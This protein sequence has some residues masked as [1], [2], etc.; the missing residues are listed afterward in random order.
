MVDID[1]PTHTQNRGMSH[2]TQEGLQAD[3][4]NN[5]AYP[6][7]IPDYVLH[8]QHIPKHHKPYLI[9][10]VGFTLNNQGQ[11]VKDLTYRG[12][13][14]IQIIECKYSTDGNIQT[15]I[16][17]KYCIYEPVRL[18]L[19]PHGT[20]KAEVKIIPIVISRTSTFHVKTLAEIAQ[21]VSFKKESLNELTFKQLPLTA[22]RI[23]I[24]LHVHAQEWVSDISKILTTK[25]GQN[26]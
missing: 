11:L 3:K 21:L 13:R 5:P 14:Q 7:S 25:K 16:D 22:K 10:A 6:Q 12:R 23:A 20:L 8:P 4:S 15:I 1:T 9:R 26:I 19:Q 24:A 18:A 17:H 2:S